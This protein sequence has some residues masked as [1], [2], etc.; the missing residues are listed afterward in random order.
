MVVEKRDDLFPYRGKKVIITLTN[1]TTI[2]GT[3]V[4]ILYGE[5]DFRSNS[6]HLLIDTEQGQKK[7]FITQCR[8][9]HEEVEQ[10]PENDVQH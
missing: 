9:I 2:K 4:N 1:G 8:A 10:T 5:V 3:L 7:I 6:C